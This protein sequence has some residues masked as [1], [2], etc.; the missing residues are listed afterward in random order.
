MSATVERDVFAPTPDAATPERPRSLTRRLFIA[1]AIVIV[2][3]FSLL[4]LTPLTVKSPLKVGQGGLI[5]L[6]GLSIV[7]AVNLAMIRRSLEPLSRLTA[8]MRRVDLLRPGRRVPVYG[9]THEVIELTRAFNEMLARLEAERRESVRRSVTAQ[10]DERLQL[11]RELHDEI[12]QSLTALLLQLDYLAR[13]APPGVASEA[14]EARESARASLEEVRRI[15]RQLRPEALDDLGLVSAIANL[16]ERVGAR[17][18]VEIERTVDRD[19]PPLSPEQELVIYRVAQESLTNVIRH[20]D[21]HHVDVSLTAENGSV[22]LRVVDDGGGL[23]GAS[24]GAGMKG[25][26]ERAVLIG[27]R[28]DIGDARSGGTEVR[29]EV[30]GDARAGTGPN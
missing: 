6:V 30:P 3:A 2:V 8:G 7:L 28:L 27:A 13:V 11:A 24:E 21:A 26:R 9:D 12:G 15:A 14:V 20:A 23:D 5:S 18:G 10:E 22:V 17:S 1:N 25:M 4:A 16:G 29:L 19:L